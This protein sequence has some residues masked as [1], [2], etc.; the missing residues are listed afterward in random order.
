MYLNAIPVKLDNSIVD[1]HDIQ[2]QSVR[3]LSS[4]D[5]ILIYGP[6]ICIVTPLFPYPL[7]N[8]QTNERSNFLHTFSTNQQLSSFATIVVDLSDT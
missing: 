6:C 7:R 4:H 2:T 3:T 8:S 5:L 1:L